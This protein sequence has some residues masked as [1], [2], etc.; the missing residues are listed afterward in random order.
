[1]TGDTQRIALVTG[2]SSG[3]GR[4]IADAMEAAGM[5]V[6]GQGLSGAESPT[7]RITLREDITQPGAGT[8]LAEQALAH[9]PRIDVLVLC[10]SVQIR[11]PWDEIAAEDAESQWRANFQCSLELV[12]ALAPAMLAQGW[13]RIL[14]IGSVQ[15]HRPHPEMPVYAATKVAQHSLVRSLAKQF[16][17]HGV[18]VNNLAPGVIDTPRNAEVLNDAPYHQ[19][20]IDQIPADRIGEVADIVPAALLLCS[21][22]AAYITG[23]DLVIDGGMSL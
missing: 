2:S 11:S 19:Q 13:G 12:Q 9:T 21:D 23:Q 5:R 20:V 18:T 3:I 4:A 7:G 8:R 17:P 1:M 15:Q 22:D 6:L 16:A 14:A 10:A